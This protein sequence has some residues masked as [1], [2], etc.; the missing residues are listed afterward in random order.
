[1][2]EKVESRQVRGEILDLLRRELV[3]PYAPDEVIS[4]NPQRRYI[5]GQLAPSPI[6]GQEDDDDEAE[7]D[8][9]SLSVV[10]DGDVLEGDEPSNESD[11]D[12]FM[13]SSPLP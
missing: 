12:G 13:C 6:D 10:G 2:I 9:E 5:I 3:G 7:F 4:E 1:M 11:E 8:A